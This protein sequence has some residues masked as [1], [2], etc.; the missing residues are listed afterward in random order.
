MH[1]D[2]FC[3]EDHYN[4]YG[5][6]KMYILLLADTEMSRQRA[7][8]VLPMILGRCTPMHYAYELIRETQTAV[9]LCILANGSTGPPPT[10][11]SRTH[12]R[13]LHV[14]MRRMAI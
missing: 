9:V 7:F 14:I 4:N 13:L 11:M 2:L 8:S 3:L 6:N 12:V 1:E 10:T 5:Q